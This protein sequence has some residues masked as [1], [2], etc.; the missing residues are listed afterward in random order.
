MGFKQRKALAFSILLLFTLNFLQAQAWNTE[1]GTS[2]QDFFSSSS[3]DALAPAWTIFFSSTTLPVAVGSHVYVGNLSG[4]ACFN[5]VD[6]RLEWFFRTEYPVRTLVY[7][8]ELYAGTMRVL[9]KISS[10]GTLLWSRREYSD[11]NVYTGGNGRIVTGS[12]MI[13]YGGNIVRKFNGTVYAAAFSGTR[14][15]VVLNGT[16]LAAYD[17]LGRIVWS[18]LF[19]EPLTFLSCSSD[20]IF[21][22]L[23]DNVV[24]L[25]SSGN[26][27]WRDGGRMLA[28]GVFRG[29]HIVLVADTGSVKAL[30]LS[31]KIMYRG[32][33][34]AAS[35]VITPDYIYVLDMF[36]TLTVLASGYTF[37]D[38][39]PTL[40]S[41]AALEGNYFIVSSSAT[42]SVYKRDIFRLSVKVYD[43][44]TPL[45][46][47]DVMVV[48]SKGVATVEATGSDGVAVFQLK[49]HDNF[50]VKVRRS[51]YYTYSTYVVG[52]P[53]ESA[54]VDVF[55]SKIVSPSY[56][57]SGEQSLWYLVA[58]AVF[59][60]AV[61]IIFLRTR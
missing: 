53:G 42:V 58:V 34:T 37:Y 61:A 36:G 4:V 29:N 52:N 10:S 33:Y 49:T 17:G 23:S 15:Y 48:D 40:G 47:V 30:D 43:G 9:Y 55:L 59:A 31:G 51:G 35:A 14:Y 3:L 46:G 6:G 50:N 38:Q 1:G 44:S 32:N 7:L 21:A 11:M 28:H 12:S 16:T 26:V 39:F 41:H 56:S 25:D 20:R 54:Y 8:D 22:T 45:A 60:A 18:K 13:D 5:I 27:L 24:C 2:A 19:S 57:F